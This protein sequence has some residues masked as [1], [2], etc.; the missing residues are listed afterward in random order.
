VARGVRSACD[1]VLARLRAEGPLTATQLGGG[2]WWDWSEVK[3]A[4][5]WLLDIGEVICVRRTGWR[6][7]YDLPERVVPDELLGV[8]LTDEQRLAGLAGVTAGALG[9]ATR[10][11]FADYHRPRRRAGSA[12][13]TCAWTRSSPPVTRDG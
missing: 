1:Q 4:A 2:P 12:A 13:M 3:G 8:E 11:D 9:V 6:R 5:E 7:V 10:A